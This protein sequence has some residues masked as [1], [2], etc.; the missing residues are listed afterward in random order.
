MGL[1]DQD[2]KEEKAAEQVASGAKTA[3]GSPKL[4][5]CHP[6]LGAA[7][8]VVGQADELNGSSSSS[9]VANEEA[10]KGEGPGLQVQADRIQFQITRDE[11]EP[12]MMTH[13]GGSKRK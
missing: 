4:P 1:N 6:E 8:K 10:T 7:A 3:G 12:D 13:H 2:T 11:P 9:A 5:V